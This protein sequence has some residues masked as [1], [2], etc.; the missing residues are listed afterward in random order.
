VAKEVSTQ[1][2]SFYYLFFHIPLPHILSLSLVITLSFLA[3]FTSPLF[4]ATGKLLSR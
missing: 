3:I 1:F 4:I 2:H